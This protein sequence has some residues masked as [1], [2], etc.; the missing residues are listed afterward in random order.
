MNSVSLQGV[1]NSE[2]LEI[3]RLI[4]VLQD[5]Q[6]ALVARQLD[7][8]AELVEVKQRALQVLERASKTREQACASLGFSA[9]HGLALWL[10]ESDESLA[11]SWQ[12]LQQQ[13][14]LAEML[15]RSNG[16]LIRGHEEAN[17]HILAGL[18]EE[19]QKETGYSAD[20]RFNHGSIT[21]RRLDQA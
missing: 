16:Q 8:V 6:E 19:R 17:R 7:R 5:E 4:V 21:G 11:T 20:G 12:V 15:N 1:L 9:E 3:E 18:C 14:R 2:L 13:A 10:A